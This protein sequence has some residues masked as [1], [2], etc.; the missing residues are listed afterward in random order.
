MMKKRR[1]S[2]ET[3]TS[4]DAGAKKRVLKGREKDAVM[5]VIGP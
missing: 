1:W 3:E 2:H 5:I 4:L